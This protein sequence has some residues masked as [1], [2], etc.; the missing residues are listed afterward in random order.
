LLVMLSTSLT[1][2][3]GIEYP[4]VSAPMDA[5]AGGELAAAVSRA[6]G[7]G[8]I[9]GGYGDADWLSAQF[10]L[11]DGARVGCGFIT[12]SLAEQPQ[13]LELALARRPVAVMLSFGDPAPFAEQVTTARVRLICQ[14]QTRCG[15]TVQLGMIRSRCGRCRGVRGSASRGMVLS[16]G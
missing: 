1:R 11:A 6:G 16:A 12:W 5:V 7:L 10:D 9:A 3:V 2:L 8:M 15:T 14:V 13:L 4:I